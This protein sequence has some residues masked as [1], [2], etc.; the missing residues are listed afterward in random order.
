MLKVISGLV[1]NKLISI[2]EPSVIE[3]VCGSSNIVDKSNIIDKVSIISKTN[4]SAFLFITVKF[5]ELVW[6]KE[7]GVRFLT[8][9]ARLAF[10][11]LK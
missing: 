4:I 3:K 11:E 9:K 2:I 7:F 6:L 8:P 10:A 1:A 5:K